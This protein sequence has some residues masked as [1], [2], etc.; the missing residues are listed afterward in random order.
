MAARTRAIAGLAIVAVL[1]LA[2]PCS[3]AAVNLFM[4]VD[5]IQGESTEANHM[6]WIDIRS[7]S[8]RV[9]QPPTGGASTSGTRKGS[10]DHADFTVTKTLD[11]A[12]PK[13]NLHC[14]QGKVLPEVKIELC[15]AAGPKS[16]V[17]VY[18]LTDCVISSVS[19]SCSSDGNGVPVEEVSLKYSRIVWA[20]TEI[21]HSTGKSK[22]IV[23]SSWH[24]SANQGG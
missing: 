6:K 24:V 1:S 7:Y 9:S 18:K 14:C 15:L 20:Y 8:H 21:D 2:R 4:K 23:E 12:S 22:G 11:K 5:G 16:K 13:L 17:M 3:A 19:V 10:A